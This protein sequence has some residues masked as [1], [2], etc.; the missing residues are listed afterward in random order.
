[1]EGNLELL[2]ITS[3]QVSFTTT[4]RRRLICPHRAKTYSSW[5]AKEYNASTGSTTGWW[6]SDARGALYLL[7]ITTVRGKNNAYTSS[8]MINW[9]AFPCVPTIKDLY[10]PTTLRIPHDLVR[11]PA[12]YLFRGSCG[13]KYISRLLP[14][15]SGF[16]LNIS[17]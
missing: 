10:R 11:W 1:M 4:S 7:L 14:V 6:R 13:P 9:L 5:K 16:S 8:R 12:I 17:L 3:Q 2:H 15:H